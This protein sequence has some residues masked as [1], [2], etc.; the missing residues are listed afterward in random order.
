M[1]SRAC[2]VARQYAASSNGRYHCVASQGWGYA[3]GKNQR[4]L[5]SSL[6]K[7]YLQWSRREKLAEWP[8]V[9]TSINQE[10][11][12]RD[13]TRAYTAFSQWWHQSASH[14]CSW[15]YTSLIGL[16]VNHG[17]KVNG[18]V[19]IITWCCYNSS[20]PPYVRAQASSSSFSSTCSPAHWA[21]EA[22]NFP[23]HNFAKCWAILKILSKQT[24]L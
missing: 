23:P 22:I 9:R 14:N 19:L 17:V 4:M 20:C 21:L 3:G 2:A 7:T 16:L 10:E 5:S 1:H 24:Q 18:G 13:K 6:M 8:T 12:R 11:R 15:Y